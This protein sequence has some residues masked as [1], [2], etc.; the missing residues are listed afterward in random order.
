[1]VHP[2]IG[3]HVDSSPDSTVPTIT[4]PADVTKSTD[5]GKATAVVTDATIGTATAND[6][7]AVQS[8]TRSGVPAGNAFPIGVT[9]ITWTATDVFGNQTI[10]T[11]KVTVVD[12][13]KPVL[14]VPAAVAVQVAGT[15]TSATIGDA[16]LGTASAT[17]NSGSVTVTRTGVPAG[18]V[19]SVGT[20]TI[21]YTA[22][23]AA[24]NSTTGT[25]TV[26]VTRQ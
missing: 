26:T 22:T 3:S 23:D 4:V 18:N 15:A 25:Q 11:Q 17:D 8:V 10:K 16:Q 12:T 20:T 24:G 21:T 9:T 13:E 5:P 19:F 7:V 2:V 6:N 1:N 14:T